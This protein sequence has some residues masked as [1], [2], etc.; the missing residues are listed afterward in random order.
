MGLEV[1]MWIVEALDRINLGVIAILVFEQLNY[2][3]EAEA[4]EAALKS[5]PHP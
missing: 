1:L 3:M 4:V 5:L 2:K